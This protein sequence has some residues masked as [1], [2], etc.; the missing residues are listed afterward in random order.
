M[1]SGGSLI[2]VLN[3]R[4][5]GILP[6]TSSLVLVVV[7]SSCRAAWHMSWRSLCAIRHG[8]ATRA[9]AT[10]RM[11]NLPAEWLHLWQKLGSNFAGTTQQ[12]IQIQF[13]G[14]S[15][16][17]W[18][19]NTL[20]TD[21]YADSA[22]FQDT[23]MWSLQQMVHSNVEQLQWTFYVSFCLPVLSWSITEH[24]RFLGSADGPSWRTKPRPPTLQPA[25]A[26]ATA[27][28]NTDDEVVMGGWAVEPRRATKNEHGDH[29]RFLKCGYPRI[30]HLFMRFSGFHFG[31]PHGTTILGSPKWFGWDGVWVWD[32]QGL[33]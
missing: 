9:S 2:F 24:D 13:G 23:C 32:F 11:L 17:K 30:M 4:G 29:G 31:V 3:C 20:W 28:G 22:W 27:Q 14:L 26:W 16:V 15:S 10:L 18:Q 1:V 21:R 8:S 33:L 5:V 12:L 6:L 25:G 7:A 19:T